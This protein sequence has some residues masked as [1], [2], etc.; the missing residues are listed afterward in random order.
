MLKGPKFL[1]GPKLY[2]L[3]LAYNKQLLLRE[4]PFWPKC[5]LRAVCIQPRYLVFPVAERRQ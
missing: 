1:L 2:T 4:P 5:L 3:L